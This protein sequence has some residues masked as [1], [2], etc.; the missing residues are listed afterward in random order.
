[1][2]EVA[3]IEYDSPAFMK[4]MRAKDHFM[5]LE[6]LIG[7]WN[8]HNPVLA[9]VRRAVDQANVIEVFRP[10]EPVL[11]LMLWSSIF[12]D[13]VH[14]LRSAFDALTFE[15][16]HLDGKR[17]VHPRQVYFP[18]KKSSENDWNKDTKNLASMPPSLLAR[19][20]AVQ[21]WS[22]APQSGH[23]ETLALI[24]GLDLEDKH[25]SLIMVHPVPGQWDLD[26]VRAWPNGLDRDGAWDA[27]WARVT[28]DRD[29]DDDVE[30]GLWELPV[31]PLVAFEHR[32]APLFDLQRWLLRQAYRVFI[33]IASGEAATAKDESRFCSGYET[34]IESSV[35]L[36]DQA[37]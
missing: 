20:K 7:T 10:K 18:A 22:G 37:N 17:P 26:A 14:N 30:P 12:G 6:H 4:M 36:D 35:W 24:H 19:L 25:R 28:I 23:G 9:P 2:P 29:I 8:Q 31:A 13:G 11:P 27:P 3:T 16:C 33:F 34:P 1:M 5:S 21:S 15:L 32:I